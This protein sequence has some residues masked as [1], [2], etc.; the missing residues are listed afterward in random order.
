MLSRDDVPSSMPTRRFL[1]RRSLSS[2]SSSNLRQE[3]N[4]RKLLSIHTC[5]LVP[6]RVHLVVSP[7]V[8]LFFL[9]IKILRKNSCERTMFPAEPSRVIFGQPDLRQIAKPYL[10]FIAVFEADVASTRYGEAEI[11][12]IRFRAI[13]WYADCVNVRSRGHRYLNM[14][15]GLSV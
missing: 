3:N 14:N 6:A 15:K 10:E 8:L 11:C 9:R 1:W 7:P 13:T 5:F 12:H 2:N 4:Y